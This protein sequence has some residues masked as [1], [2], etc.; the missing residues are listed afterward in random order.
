M[1]NSKLHE[2]SI[3]IRLKELYLWP[4]EASEVISYRHVQTWSKHTGKTERMVFVAKRP[5]KWS[6]IGVCR[7][8]ASIQVRLKE[9]YLWTKEA[10]ELISFIMPACPKLPSRCVLHTHWVGP[11]YATVVSW[12]QCVKR[13]PPRESYK[14]TLDD[15]L[16]IMGWV[17]VHYSL[18]Q[19]T[20]WSSEWCAVLIPT[21]CVQSSTVITKCTCLHMKTHDHKART[22][23]SAL[24]EHTAELALFMSFLEAA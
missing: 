9:W 24:C 17:W 4:K 15:W 20:D 16:V 19:M 23:I 6:V 10:S 13:P 12:Y 21:A 18:K 7:H 22:R 3:H 14:G 8:E 11:D 1:C 2:A 5:Q